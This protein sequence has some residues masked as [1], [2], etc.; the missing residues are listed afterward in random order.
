MTP[1]TLT[2]RASLVE[3]RQAPGLVALILPYFIIK[4]HANL[5]LH[6]FLKV[7]S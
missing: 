5:H 1:S 3:H 4:P 7:M 2:R 6:E